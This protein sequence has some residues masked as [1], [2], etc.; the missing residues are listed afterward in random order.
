[1]K[2]WR[3]QYRWRF[4]TLDCD[5]K[6][7]EVLFRFFTD[8]QRFLIRSYKRKL[9]NDPPGIEAK[10]HSKKQVLK[11]FEEISM[12]SKSMEENHDDEMVA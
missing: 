11:A 3:L 4:G 2:V 12:S 10:A 7:C 9:Q 1:M 8:K 5:R 6:E